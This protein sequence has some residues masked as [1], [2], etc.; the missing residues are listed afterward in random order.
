MVTP[1]APKMMQLGTT[2]RYSDHSLHAAYDYPVPVG[3]TARAVRDGTILATHDGVANN[4]APNH[5]FSGAPVNFVMLGSTFRGRPISILYLHLSPGLS[6]RTGQQVKAG[7]KIGRSGN[8]GH[9]FG[10][11]LHV[12]VMFGHHDEASKFA[13]LSGIPHDEAPPKRVA[14]NGVTIYPPNQVYGRA[15]PGPFD[16][17]LVVVDDLHFGVRDSDSVRR[18]QQRLNH[19]SLDR[20]VELPVTGNY[21][22]MTRDE[23]R[24]WQVQKDVAEPGTEAADGN[25]GPLQARKLFPKA[26]RVRDHA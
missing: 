20:G 25:L 11:H 4:V 18:L 13:Y 22:K 7:Q 10:P 14:S 21:L 26:Y 24:K 19:I 17:G 8:S 9:S 12:A 3:T 15:K 2:W 1:L 23:V 16:A 5:G 6:V